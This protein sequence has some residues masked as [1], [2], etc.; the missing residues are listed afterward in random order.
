MLCLSYEFI[1]SVAHL[2]IHPTSILPVPHSFLIIEHLLCAGC[3][4]HWEYI[5]KETDRFFPWA[6]YI[7]GRIQILNHK[8]HRHFNISGCTEILDNQGK[9]SGESVIQTEMLKVS[10][11]Y[12]SE[13]ELG[14]SKKRQNG[15]D[16][17]GKELD[18]FGRLRQGPSGSTMENKEGK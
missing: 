7:P 12:L 10:R 17:V 2:S 13:R 11:S 6:A 18:V 3:V 5:S 15:I 9:L 4:E 1:H 14:V 8:A 16:K